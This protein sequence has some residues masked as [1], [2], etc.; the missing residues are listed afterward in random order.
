MPEQSLDPQLVDAFV[1]AAH[2]DLGKVR[3]LL[4]REPALRDAR[5]RWGET[6]LGAAAHTGAVAVLECLLEH[7]A[8]L[9]VFAAAALGRTDRVAGFLDREPSL[10]DARGAHGIPL[11]AHAAAGGRLDVAELLLER[12]GDV[13]AGAGGTTALHVAAAMGR[14]DFAAWL[15]QRGADPGVRDTQGRTPLDLATRNGHD[16]VA[17]LLRAHGGA[18]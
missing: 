8:E 10:V 9:D 14:A 4:A 13:N 17:A 11:L 3:E 2:G 6:P 16:A 5:A 18:A 12:G 7:G 15:L 1:I